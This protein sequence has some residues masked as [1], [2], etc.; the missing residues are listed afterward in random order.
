MYLS[1]GAGGTGNF[2]TFF[3]TDFHESSKLSFTAYYGSTTPW[4]VSSASVQR[5]TSS[6]YHYV[7]GYGSTKLNII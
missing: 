4:Y 2:G 7:C 6:W 3:G 5:D 1:A